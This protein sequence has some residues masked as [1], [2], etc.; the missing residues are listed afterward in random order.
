MDETPQSVRG[1]A[2]PVDDKESRWSEAVENTD[3]PSKT[4]VPYTQ[5]VLK[6]T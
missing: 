4:I 6:T 3:S 1:D 5:K 2:G